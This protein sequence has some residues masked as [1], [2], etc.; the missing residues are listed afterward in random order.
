MALSKQESMQSADIIP[1]QAEIF[2]RLADKN[3]ES[4]SACALQG[5]RVFV[6]F[7]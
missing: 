3:N 7:L 1:S 4:S 2:I 6:C 5:K